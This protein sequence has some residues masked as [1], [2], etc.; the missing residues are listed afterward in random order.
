MKVFTVILLFFF[1][2]WVMN[3][4]ATK[5]SISINNPIPAIMAT[6]LLMLSIMIIASIQPCAVN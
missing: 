5:F 2:G 1:F 6:I 3:K 4:I